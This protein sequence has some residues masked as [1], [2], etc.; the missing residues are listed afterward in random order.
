MEEFVISIIILL[1]LLFLG[2][3]ASFSILTGS[4]VF[5]ILSR[6][7][8]DIP[9]AQ[10]T[11]SLVYGIDSFPLLAIPTFILMAHILTDARVTPLIFDFCHK[12][13]GHLRGGLAH[14]NIVA[15]M[16]FAGKS[17]SGTA[18]VA[19]I[20]RILY[21]N[22][23]EGGYDKRYAAAITGASSVV[24]PIIPP[25]I[26]A[27]M[28]A[29]IA[30]LSVIDLF[31]ACLGPGLLIGF[32]LLVQVTIIAKVKNLNITPRADILTRFRSTYRAIPPL[33]VPVVLIGGILSGQFTATE[34]G[35]MAA[36]LAV[37]LGVIVYRT[38][39]F[40]KLYATF[41]RTAND[42][43]KIMILVAVS[44]LFSW[45]LARY[46]V[47]VIIAENLLGVTENVF[48][49]VGLFMMFLLIVG[50]FI[51]VV[52]AVNLVTPIMAPM[53]VALGLDPLAF[54]AMTIIILSIGNLTPP[55]GVSLYV[56]AD[57]TEI[58]FITLAWYIV[59]FLITIFSIGVL[60][61]AFPAIPNF[62]PSLVN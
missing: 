50:C 39:G 2:V 45:I 22:M 31:L 5:F 59:P 37:I 1:V 54:G 17:G 19:G 23:V 20:G 52:V 53:A 28:Y 48:I 21:Q 42:T 34:S 36:F 10:I 41:Q 26:P 4:F 30:E 11:R 27:V 7:F 62:I 14:V 43:A 18:D 44:S 29:V 32:A 12:W 9:Y 16:I 8:L 25:S 46:R 6:G 33:M 13:V 55:F 57:Y 61:I 56:L 49:L 3:P 58:P 40:K 38:I 24:G 35:A 47:P 15:S 60:T 51:S